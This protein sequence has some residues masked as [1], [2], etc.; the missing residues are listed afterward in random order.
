MGHERIESDDVQKP[1]ACRD[2]EYSKKMI[3]GIQEQLV[4]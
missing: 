4:P 2:C 3:E 1:L